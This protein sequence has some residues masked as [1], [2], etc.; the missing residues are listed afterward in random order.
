[1]SYPGVSA[2]RFSEWPTCCDSDFLSY[3]Y[4]QLDIIKRVVVEPVES[5]CR[6]GRCKVALVGGHL[7]IRAKRGPTLVPQT[8]LSKFGNPDFLADLNGRSLQL[9]TVIFCGR[10]AKLIFATLVC[11]YVDEIDPEGV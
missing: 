5:S 6:V 3:T 1:M 10:V 9:N 7:S 11:L 4:V 8:L 2:L